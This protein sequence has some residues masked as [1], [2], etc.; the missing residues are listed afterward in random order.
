VRGFFRLSV[1]WASHFGIMQIL[2]V[3]RKLGSLCYGVGAMFTGLVQ[4][5]GALGTRSVRGPG[6][7][8]EVATGFAGL[9]LGESVAV[10]GACL[11]VAAIVS[12]GFAADLS[13]ETLE[14]TTLGR[15]PEGAALN[16]ERALALGDRLGGHLV[17]GH[18]DGIGRIESVERVGEAQKLR[19]RAPAELARFIAAK[20]SICVDGVSL[21]VNAVNAIDTT[22]SFE[23]EVML[24]PQTLAL[25]TLA[26]LRVGAPVNLEIDLLARYAVR[27][28]EVAH[29]PAPETP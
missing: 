11:T 27:W 14:K 18:V 22:E 21:T 24:I 28:L 19:L 7:R 8:I 13:A 16:L 5:L 26:E 12:G 6:A 25:T 20:G 3:S 23:F 15:L 2:G 9:E 10:Q 4:A 29:T 1:W 17:Q